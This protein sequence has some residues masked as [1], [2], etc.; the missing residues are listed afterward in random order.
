MRSAWLID[1]AVM[2][3]QPWQAIAFSVFTLTLGWVA[4]DG[5]CRSPLGREPVRL[6][7]GLDAGIF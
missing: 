5:L 4:Y 6:A 7:A 1:P 3:L 2:D